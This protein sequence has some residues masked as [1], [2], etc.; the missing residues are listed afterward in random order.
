MSHLKS[1]RTTGNEAEASCFG[2][3]FVLL[4]PSPRKTTYPPLPKQN[5]RLAFLDF[6]VFFSY[7]IIT[8]CCYPRELFLSN[9]ILSMRLYEY[10][11]NRQKKKKEKAISLRRSHSL[12]CISL[13][14]FQCKLQNLFI[15]IICNNICTTLTII[16]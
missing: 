16:W 8:K 12:S 1:P 15:K 3:G 10:L 6:M 5:N 2:Q 14:P 4:W 13:S 11:M 9:V 7:Y